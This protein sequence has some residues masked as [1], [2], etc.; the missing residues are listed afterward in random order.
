MEKYRDKIAGG[1]GK[2]DRKLSQGVGYGMP[3][4][5]GSGNQVGSAER[6]DKDAEK[7]S[8]DQ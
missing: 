1:E 7:D 4:N 5:V 8:P 6:I 2:D 3:G